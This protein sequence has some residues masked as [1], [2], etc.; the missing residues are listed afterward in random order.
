MKQ[1]NNYAEDPLSPNEDL[2]PVKLKS[3]Y[4]EPDTVIKVVC[5]GIHSGLLT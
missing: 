2:S 3:E 5:G 4:F 1:S